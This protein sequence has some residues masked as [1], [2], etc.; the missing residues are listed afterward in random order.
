MA[1]TTIPVLAASSGS[2]TGMLH[3]PYAVRKHTD[4]CWRARGGPIAHGPLPAC[5][6]RYITGFLEMAQCRNASTGPSK[7]R[8]QRPI[9]SLPLKFTPRIYRPPSA[10]PVQMLCCWASIYNIVSPQ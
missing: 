3:E 5:Q 4:Q 6:R 7:I 2:V 10:I 1:A 8:R 9:A